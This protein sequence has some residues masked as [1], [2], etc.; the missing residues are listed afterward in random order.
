[1]DADQRVQSMKVASR[2]LYG[3]KE[4]NPTILAIQII[5]L[6]L[7]VVTS[8]HRVPPST[9]K[10]TRNRM[11]RWGLLIMVRERHDSCNRRALHARLWMIELICPISRIIGTISYLTDL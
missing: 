11:V 1:M 3:K 7:S 8:L 6:Y 9:P 2:Q 4:E 10:M 5:E